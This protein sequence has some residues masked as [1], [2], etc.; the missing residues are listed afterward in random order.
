MG[1]MTA[2]VADYM[3]TSWDFLSNLGNVLRTSFEIAGRARAASELAR[4]GYQKEA[5]A[6]MMEI[7]SI[8]AEREKNK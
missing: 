2:I 1:V 7:Q 8:R 6:L 4:L 5:K 3:T